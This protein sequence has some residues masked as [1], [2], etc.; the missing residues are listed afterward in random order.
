MS[1]TGGF[2]IFPLLFIFLYL[3]PEKYN[4][5]PEAIVASVF[6]LS[7][8]D[9]KIKSSQLLTVKRLKE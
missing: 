5:F 1:P 3:L 9:V 4:N 8:M 2:A 7:E 6:L